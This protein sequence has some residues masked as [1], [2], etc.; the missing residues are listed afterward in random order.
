[1]SI[2]FLPCHTVMLLPLCYSHCS[3]CYWTHLDSA[4]VVILPIDSNVST[5]LHLCG[6]L[7]VLEGTGLVSCLPTWWYVHW[8]WEICPSQGGLWPLREQ[9]PVRSCDI[10]HLS[11][12][13]MFVATPSGPVLKE[14][15]TGLWCKP[16]PFL[17][18]VK[19]VQI[20]ISNYIP[21]PLNY[22]FAF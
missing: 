17:T 10:Y 20:S 2:L 6:C 8:W 9:N 21:C 4:Q 5:S 15:R 1:M 11:P 18:R 19:V 12:W 7:P 14:V 13:K 16:A 22:A 3:P